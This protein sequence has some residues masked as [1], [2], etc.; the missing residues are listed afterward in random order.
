LL[1]TRTPVQCNVDVSI[2]EINSTDARNLGVEYGSAT[3]LSESFDPGGPIINPTTGAILGVTPSSTSRTTDNAFN[4]GVT[5][6]GRRFGGTGALQI[7]DPLRYRINA[8]MSQGKAHILSNPRTTVLSGRTATFQV[9]G[10]VPIPASSTV[11]ANGTTTA[12]VFKDF[13]V[14][15]DIV[16]NALPNG[17]VTVRI[18]T[19]VSQPDFG[20][21]VT[22]PG[23]GSP[24]P[25]FRRRSS[26][27]EVT[28][29]QNGTV[30]LSGLISA[31]EA[32]SDSSVP[33]LS[34]IPILG[35]L[36]RSKNFRKNQSE[37]VIFVKPRVL[38]NTLLD[39]T[40]APAGVVAVGENT[41][42]A[43]Q[44]GNPGLR[45]FDAGAAIVAPTG[46]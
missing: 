35:A 32:I 29:P 11:G 7:L 44:M 21:G 46:Q 33:I 19:E 18:R 39:G 20:V 9:G 40:N 28:V 13:G 14:L 24:I 8:L 12:I 23:G 38:P 17:N 1:R 6:A 5:V 15:L 30:A 4:Q 31:D 3:L 34:R 27:T 42:A 43:A 36:F 25:G 41:N 26:V 45:V 16:P 22:P 10:Q 2:I 37:L